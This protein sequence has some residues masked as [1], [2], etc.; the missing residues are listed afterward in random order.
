MTGQQRLAIDLTNRGAELREPVVETSIGTLRSHRA[1]F[2]PT[3][4]PNQFDIDVPEGAA[5]LALQLHGADAERVSS[6]LYLYDCTSGECFS[7]DFTLPAVKE[8]TFVVRRPKAGRWV[9][10]VNAAPFP[11]KRGRFV[12]DEIITSDVRRHSAAQSGPRRPGAEWTETID[13]QAPARLSQSGATPVLLCELLDI[14][15]ER[16]AAAN[17]WEVR[18]GLTNLAD[19]SVAAGMAIFPQR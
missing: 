18:E 15:A 5:T 11:A 13:I 14:A 8:H 2:L 1:E 4:L 3:G 17:R 7:Y 10:A 9:A 19:H 12:L 16:E 6:E